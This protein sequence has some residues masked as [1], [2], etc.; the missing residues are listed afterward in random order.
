MSDFKYL[1]V[2]ENSGPV[3]PK[4]IYGVIEHQFNDTQ[5]DLILP[6]HG[7]SA[8]E[9][10]QKYLFENK[11]KQAVYVRRYLPET[12]YEQYIDELHSKNARKQ[13]ELF[14]KEESKKLSNQKLEALLR[15]F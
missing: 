10:G 9:A 4:T 7:S 6:L 3:T 5:L 11:S 15:E 8:E 13:L 14:Q 12:K 2:V 1:K